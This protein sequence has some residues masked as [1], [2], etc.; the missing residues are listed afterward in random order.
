MQNLT[1]DVS[2]VSTVVRQVQSRR[3]SLVSLNSPR[4]TQSTSEV[5]GWPLLRSLASRANS[6]STFPNSNHPAWSASSPLKRR[7]LKQ[8]PPTRVMSSS[9]CVRVFVIQSALL[10]FLISVVVVVVVVWWGRQW[11]LFTDR[12]SSVPPLLQLNVS[13]HVL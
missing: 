3:R 8:A 7:L 4:W 2:S 1:S 12:I 10:L 13:V 5:T 6:D 11:V 9:G